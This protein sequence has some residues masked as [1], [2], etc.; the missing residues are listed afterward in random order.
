[1]LILGLGRFSLCRTKNFIH[2]CNCCLQVI[3]VITVYITAGVRTSPRITRRG[4]I[5]LSHLLP[6]CRCCVSRYAFC[7]TSGVLVVQKKRP[8]WSCEYGVEVEHGRVLPL[9]AVVDH[10]HF[11]SVVINY[12]RIHNE[13]DTP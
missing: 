9:F 11:R 6:G 12:A 10:C 5:A 3:T 7:I 2:R 4:N 13:D 8:L 1:M